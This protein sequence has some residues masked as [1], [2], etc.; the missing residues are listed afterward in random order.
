MLIKA[1]ETNSQAMCPGCSGRRSERSGTWKTRSLVRSKSC[2]AASR[3]GP[4]VDAPLRFLIGS[5]EGSASSVF[6]HENR[7]SLQREVG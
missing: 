4:G 3:R 1:S 2:F 5:R 6:L 7:S